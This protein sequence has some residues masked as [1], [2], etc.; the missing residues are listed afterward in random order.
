MANEKSV[1]GTSSIVPAN[2]PA[3][4]PV[5]EIDVR[6]RYILNGD[7]FGLSIP[8]RMNEMLSDSRIASILASGAFKQAV[9]RAQSMG[10]ALAVDSAGNFRPVNMPTNLLA[11][12]AGAASGS[13]QD[14]NLTSL[15][16]QAR[17]ILELNGATLGSFKAPLRGAIFQGVT[18]ES[19]TA[20]IRF[21]LKNGK[22][23]T[24]ALSFDK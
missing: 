3:K 8:V 14:F 15:A 23:A 19:D 1:S 9:L 16:E 20:Y 11:L 24:L 17:K 18:V 2:V 7:A 5:A 13:T 12:G 10:M 6:T 22:K 21:T 4:T